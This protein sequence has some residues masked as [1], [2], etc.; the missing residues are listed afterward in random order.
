MD[1]AVSARKPMFAGVL[2]GSM[3]SPMLYNL[4][5]PDV[6]KSV[7]TELSV[8]ADDMYLHSWLCN[9]IARWANESRINIGSEKRRL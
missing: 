5:T 1:S 7:Q 8:Y 2:Q 9:E 3:L 4:Y 6:A